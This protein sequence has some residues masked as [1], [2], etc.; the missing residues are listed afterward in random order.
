MKTKL[1]S[2]LCAA[3]MAVAMG[4]CVAEKND[5]PCNRTGSLSGDMLT[6]TL[7]IP[8]LNTTVPAGR[9]MN[10]AQE[11]DVKSIDLLAFGEDGKF[12]Y[13]FRSTDLTPGSATN[14]R[15]CKVEVNESQSGEKYTLVFLAN[16]PA[17]YIESLADGFDGKTK[18]EVFA[19][20]T[21]SGSDYYHTAGA[22]AGKWISA[23]GSAKPFPM[24]G[25]HAAVKV[26]AATRLSGIVM[27]RSVA[28][29]DVGLNFKTKDESETPIDYT[30][31]AI[32]YTSNYAA[33]GLS[34]FE[35]VSVQVRNVRTSG[36]A[37]PLGTNF[38]DEKPSV[39]GLL[40]ADKKGMIEYK[41]EIVGGKQLIREIYIAES[42]IRNTADPKDMT[43][44]LIEGKYNGG[45]PT[46]YRVDFY[47][48]DAQGE[49]R[50]NRLDI[51][52][53]Y[54]Y[55]VN[56]TGVNGD[57]YGDADDALNSDPYNLE[58]NVI[59]WN[60][61]RID[62]VQIDGQNYVMV[63]PRDFNFGF[64]AVTA[65]NTNNKLTVQTNYSGGWSIDT[66]SITYT[67]GTGW[68]SFS[69]ASGAGNGTKQSVSLIM[70]LN[71][72]GAER[73]ATFNVVA[74]RMRVPVTVKQTSGIL[75]PPGVLGVGV[76]SKKLTLKGSKEYDAQGNSPAGSAGETVYAVYFKWGSTVAIGQGTGHTDEFDASD[77]AWAPAEFD[78]GTIT[79]DWTSVPYG[80]GTTSFPAQ[81]NAA[82]LGDPCKL[83][84]NNGGNYRMNPSSEFTDGG[85]VT[86]YSA[87]VPTPGR[88]SNS[89]SIK[90]QFYPLVGKR[91]SQGYLGIASLQGSFYW[92][93]S[94]TY[95]GGAYKGY[96][97]FM[98]ATFGAGELSTTR[99]DYGSPIRCVEYTP[100]VPALTVTG[101]ATTDA[102][103]YT[104]GTKTYSVSSYDTATDS[105]IA[106]KAEF[107]T[108]GTNWTATKPTWL[109]AFTTS[110]A[111]SKTAA[112]YDAT[113]QA[114][115]GVA[116]CPEDDLLKA[117]A[118]V[119]TSA[120]PHDLS[121]KGAA[122]NGT[123]RNTANCYVI[124]A[125][126]Y[127]KLPLVYG[128]AI[129]AGATNTSAYSTTT[130]TNKLTAFV[131]HDN[132]AIT[133]PYIYDQFTPYDATLVWMDAPGLIEN[134][135]LSGDGHYLEFD[136]PAA[137]IKQGNAIVAVRNSSNV[138][139][140][141]WHIWVTAT[142]VFDAANPQTD[143][144]AN[145]TAPNTTFNF[146]KYNLGWCNMGTTKYGV[147][148][149]NDEPRSV[150][151]R[152]SQTG[153]EGP[154]T[155]T[156]TITQNNGKVIRGGN[157]PYW[158]WG[159]KDPMRP[160]AG[161]SETAEKT[162]YYGTGGYTFIKAPNG[163]VALGTAI[164]NPNTFY[165]VASVADNWCS[166]TYNNLWS[167]ENTVTTVNTTKPVKTVYDPSPV[168]FVMP[169]SGAWTGFT[170]DGNNVTFGGPTNCNVSGA[171][172]KGWN[173]YLGLNGT[174]GT[175]FYPTTGYRYFQTGA[176]LGVVSFANCWSGT[177]ASATVGYNFYFRDVAV[178]PQYN[179]YLRAYGFAARSVAE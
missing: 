138:I 40:A 52:R 99:S 121:T 41:N 157:N 16:M 69:S 9:A 79:D 143:A 27:V 168:G 125:P 161:T 77:V 8:G 55:I 102:Y 119:A 39:A 76:D 176:F 129:K 15:I 29:I 61:E 123:N 75:A 13:T 19:Q 135:E 142:T 172:D 50:S 127:Y 23:S 47:D 43:C 90:S 82:G 60:D 72:S 63:S 139:L 132:A 126:G 53:N 148:P 116:Y 165:T 163:A 136:V 62:P 68:L 178:Y 140:W 106:W 58:S 134:I 44:L 87:A 59:Y 93:P 84:E 26:A 141:S 160:A 103:V 100:A 25:E 32:D 46:W 173:F 96:A 177:P 170:S 88:W 48:R 21:F 107:S 171:F 109:T 112:N 113:T 81:N 18:Q 2:I 83:A 150:Q 57:G 6:I 14:E 108:D 54:R 11:N 98:S 104:S 85:W 146:M 7:R 133:G 38:A 45:D 37:A 158:Q 33:E 20:I 167:M 130:G 149:N 56:I 92:L 67:G 51:L 144:T 42:D 159:R 174:G 179:N 175:T 101:A 91:D 151:V 71:V 31:P 94:A 10:Q 70:P 22:D 78:K 122:D 124:N 30:D 89:G 114:F 152:V 115:T 131:R 12:A 128:N 111:G 97:L 120:A 24:W 4:S 166:T 110:A 66:G 28:R 17:G 154:L 34:N 3:V 80:A 137:N 153:I 1:L 36:Y 64:N 5:G 118:V 117:A 65:A 162:L 147:G 155:E 86:Q 49:A 35:I 74:G 164:A 156:F 145:R 95:S 169:P 105:P 73:T